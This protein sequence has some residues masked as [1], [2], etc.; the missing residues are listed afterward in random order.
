M[1]LIIV[2]TVFIQLK[3]KIKLESN[4][5]VCENKCFCNVVMSSEDTKILEFNQY[6]KSDKVA[7]IIYVY[8]ESL[9]GKINECKKTPEFL[10]KKLMGVK[11]IL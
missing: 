1:V 7:F 8:L 4:I 9:I 3:Q 11:K 5:K 2:W 10:Q 6:R